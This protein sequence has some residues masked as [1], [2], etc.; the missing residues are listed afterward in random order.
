MT[1][2]AR[3]AWS[4]LMPVKVLAQAK[5]RLAVL[6]GPRRGELALA[7]ACDTVAA[8][9]ASGPVA[10]RVIVITDDQVAGPAL[11]ALGALVVPDEPRDGLNAALRHGAAHATARWPGEGT[12]AL[13]A[14][15]PALRPDELGRTLRAAAAW[16]SAFVADA[17]GDGT[18]LYATAP[19]ILFRPAF[20][21]ASRSR[22]AAGGAVELDL[23]GIPGLRRDVDTP[24]DLRVAVT[25]GL[26]P[27]S[28]PVAA[29]LLRCAPRGR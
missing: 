20:G 9:L 21:L 7:L 28:A 6:A 3:F 17:T 2:N 1:D 4:V 18:T 26:G 25:L 27:R 29:E 5:S 13:S 11:A 10:A 14:D 23:D 16:P 8:V 15:L 24:D 22:H 19:G 12:V